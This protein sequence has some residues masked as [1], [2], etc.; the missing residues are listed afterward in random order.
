MN[1]IFNLKPT[2]NWINGSIA[3]ILWIFIKQKQSELGP[4]ISNIDQIIYMI[5]KSNKIDK[6]INI[7]RNFERIMALIEEK[8]SN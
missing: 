1:D 7:L 8:N 4:N 2:V 6:T 5:T 3:S